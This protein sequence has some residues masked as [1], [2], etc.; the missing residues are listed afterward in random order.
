MINYPNNEKRKEVFY[1]GFGGNPGSKKKD[2]FLLGENRQNTASQT[3]QD[4]Q[5]PLL[6]GGR[7][8]EAERTNG[9]LSHGQIQ[10]RR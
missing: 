2:I 7:Y 5:L 4:G 8:K 9:E 1:Q 6:V 10:K 3:N